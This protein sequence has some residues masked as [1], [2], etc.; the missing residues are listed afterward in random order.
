MRSAFFRARSISKVSFRTFPSSLSATCRTCT[1]FLYALSSASFSAEPVISWVSMRPFSE[2][3]ASIAALVSR[4]S[5]F[6]CFSCVC[7]SLLLAVKCWSFSCALAAL[8]CVCLSLSN[9]FSLSRSTA[10]MALTSD[11]ASPLASLAR[12]AISTRSA[13]SPISTSWSRTRSFLSWVSWACWLAC[14]LPTRTCSRSSSASSPSAAPRAS[15]IRRLSPS[16]RSRRSLAAASSD[17]SVAITGSIWCS[18]WLAIR[19]AVVSS[20]ASSAC[21]FD[22]SFWASS[23]ARSASMRASS[24]VVIRA[25]S[26]STSSRRLTISARCSSMASLTCRTA[27]SSSVGATFWAASIR[28]STSCFSTLRSTRAASSST[29]RVF[30]L[31][32]SSYAWSSCATKSSGSLPSSPSSSS[33]SSLSSLSTLASS[34]SALPASSFSSPPLSA[35][36]SS[37]PLSSSSFFAPSLSTSS[38]ETMSS[39]FSSLP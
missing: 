36:A 34:S 5:R 19:V 23:L 2:A 38:L 27:S 35:L 26:S 12:D 7:R 13:C 24:T 22:R 32:S 20:R 3:V 29:H 28:S 39:A 31:S 37:F 21:C 11:L 16:S 14:S 25:F 30:V 15:T 6:V 9:P 10:A 17:R 18:D 1:T 4:I 33:S 8:S